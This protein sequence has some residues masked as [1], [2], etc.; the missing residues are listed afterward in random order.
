MSE[1]AQPRYAALA[2]A[3]RADI[4]AARMRPGDP[5]PTEAQLTARFG[6]SRF[7]VREALRTLASEGLIVRKRGSGTVVAATRPALR[8]A[9]SDTQALLQYAQASSFCI[10]PAVLTRL[11]P[12]QAA[13]LQRPAGEPWLHIR[14]IRVM[15]G[16]A[17]PVAVTDAFLHPR[18]QS[19]AAALTSGHEALF[20]Q[21]ERLAGLRIGRVTQEIQAVNAT[22]AEAR[23]L[24]IPKG[25]A[26]LRIIRHY[27][28]QASDLVEMS[29]SVHPG[30]RFS[31]MVETS[32]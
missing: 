7:T 12:A 9:L 1:R 11:R 23:V 17:E 4:R 19:V 8:Q 6:V 26:C 31:Y 13:M 15:D 14:G 3:L 2:D 16:A 27:F 28:D 25:A 22:A 24:A 20:A 30:T 21:L 5:L 29:C 18:F 10:A 32:S